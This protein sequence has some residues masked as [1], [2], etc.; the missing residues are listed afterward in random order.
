MK[1][2][3]SFSAPIPESAAR[4]RAATFLTQA[5]YIQ[6]SDSGNYLHFRR[7]S[8]IGALINFDPRRW[9]C[10][11][12]IHIISN[13]S[14]SEIHVEAEIST[15]PTEKRFAEE[16]LTTEFSLLEAAITTNEFKTFDI[17]ELKKK[18]KS[19]VYRIAGIFTSFMFSII[20]GI[21]VGLF[22]SI[23]LNIAIL[24]ASVLG[25][26]VSLLMFTIF[27]LLWGRQKKT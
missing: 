18:I 12:N 6:L 17:S 21:V 15:D 24:D 1:I 5:G 3:R 19:H 20:L 26:G 14:P 4:E 25:A 13:E 2:V 7:G 9:Q 11:V 8:T 27:I 10:E 22:A 16:L 23:D